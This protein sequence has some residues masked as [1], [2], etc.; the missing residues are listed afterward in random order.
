MVDYSL[1]QYIYIQQD[2]WQRL[3]SSRVNWENR[4]GEW[5]Y[6]DNRTGGTWI[7]EL[8]VKGE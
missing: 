7:I 2:D 6:K 4:T 3:N 8:E 1:I 5:R